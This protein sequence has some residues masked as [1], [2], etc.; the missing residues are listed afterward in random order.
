MAARVGKQAPDFTL[1]GTG[2]TKYHLADYRG[3]VVVLAFYPGDDS[4]VC[5]LQLSSY[6]TD[7]EQ[8]RELNAVVF[9]INP[10][11][12]ESHESFKEKRDLAFELLVDEDKAVGRSYGILGP[13]G[14]YRRS[15][16][17][18]DAEGIVRY[19]HRSL[20]GAT[21][22]SSAELLEAVRAAHRD[23]A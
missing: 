3:Q 23:A 10:Q 19:V 1:V 11:G 5:T 7:I 12:V 17:V 2:G 8:F 4:S 15:I 18:I 6:S 9:G 14:F 20:S 22:K 13:L 16:F 21:F